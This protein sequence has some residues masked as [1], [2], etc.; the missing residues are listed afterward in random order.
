MPRVPYPDPLY[1]VVWADTPDGPDSPP[2]PAVSGLPDDDDPIQL[3]LDE[4]LVR[5]ADNGTVGR[6]KAFS[7]PWF[8][9]RGE[10]AA[11]RWKDIEQGLNE[12]VRRP[13]GELATTRQ[14]NMYRDIMEPRLSA[15]GDEARAHGE[16]QAQAFN[17][18]E[19]QRRQDIA[20]EAMR[21]GARLNDMRAV[22][23]G[24]R[25]LVGEVRG[26]SRRQ[27][28]DPDT[29]SAA[30]TDAR[31]AAH[32]DV[33]QH[34]AQHDPQRAQA[35]LNA[36]AGM[37]ADPVEVDRLSRMLQ[38]YVAEQQQEGLADLIR[39][40]GGDLPAQHA[41]VDAMGLDP[42]IADGLKQRLAHKAEGDRRAAEKEQ[43]V[44]FSRLMAAVLDP[45]MQSPRGISLSDYYM[46]TPERQEAAR[47]VMAANLRG[48]G[49]AAKPELYRNLADKAAQGKLSL[50]DM[51]GNDGPSPQWEIPDQGNNFQNSDAQYSGNDAEEAD[52]IDE[53]EDI[54]EGS[55][56]E[57]DIEHDAPS[58]PRGGVININL[59]KPVPRKKKIPID[60]STAIRNVASH[61]FGSQSWADAAE[62]KDPI[63]GNVYGSNSN[64]CSL[65][66]AYVLERAGA[67]PGYP[68]FG[69]IRFPWERGTPPTA[70][71]DDVP[72]RGVAG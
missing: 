63:T 52:N 59:N 41:A 2:T 25:R 5:K 35:W 68:N 39:D 36:H 46:L 49:P 37:I 45:E 72:G 11:A 56:Y 50:N 43:D 53:N 70:D 18:A 29:A 33:V 44:A 16:R 3:H 15:W 71:Q 1:P 31:A 48:E 9:A 27:G 57:D 17:D 4:A 51:H 20:L 21:R 69:D 24:E 28:L 22:A 42:A 66:V 62:W 8:D 47:A 67:S 14:R 10:E 12:I 64:K 7:G 19:S 40:E 55:N 54:S 58:A 6:W 60:K 30:E 13:L 23:E 32:S 34:L 38:P 65:F 61:L 26:R